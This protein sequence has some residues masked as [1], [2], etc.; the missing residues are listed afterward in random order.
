LD[1]CR[2]RDSERAA[3]CERRVTR[4]TRGAARRQKGRDKRRIDGVGH[5]VSK[6]VRSASPLIGV[7]LL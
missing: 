1:L 7:G 4:Q 2:K 3:E 5:D 6:I